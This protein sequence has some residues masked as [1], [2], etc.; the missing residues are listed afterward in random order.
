MIRRSALA[1]LL[2]TAPAAAMAEGTM[3]QMDFANPLTT[4]Q[5]VWMVVILV[6]LYFIL[7]RW[8]LPQIGAVLENRATTI[9][10]DLEAARAAK[11]AADKAVAELNATMKKARDAAQADIAKAE[12]DAKAKALADAKA[13]A[14]KLDAQLAYSEKLIAESRAA[15]LA[16]IKPV[17]EAASVEIL[18]RLTAKTPD[19]ALLSP[20][21]D[22]ALAARKAA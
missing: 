7:S 20:Q 19:H 3:P 9:A 18:L 2:T 10:R 14:A 12:S 8:G 6:A 21:I 11:A 16:A 15:A 4:S 17:A 1:I 5:V 22:A 13:L